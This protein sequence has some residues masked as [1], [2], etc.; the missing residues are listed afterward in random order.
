MRRHIAQLCSI[1]F[2]LLLPEVIY[3]AGGLSDQETGLISE[4]VEKIRSHSLVPPKSTR[5]MTEDILRSYSRTID[6]YGD[7]LSRE[8]FS[9]FMESTNSDYFGVQM[10]IRKKAGHIYLFPFK[11]GSAEKSGIQ[12]GDELVAINGAPVYGKSVFLIGSTIRGVEGK[13][14]QLTIRSGKG[15]PRVLSLRRQETSYASVRSATYDDGHYI[16]LTRFTKNTDTR[17][18]EILA[19]IDGDDR[20]VVVDLRGNQG[21]S[22]RVARRCADFFLKKDT[23]L[24]KLRYRDVTMDIVAEE[25]ALNSSSMVIIQDN[26]TASAAEAFIAALTGNGRAVALGSTTYG[27]GLA[28][29][30]LPLSDGSALLL[31]YAEILSPDNF[32][33]NDVGFKPDIVL[34]KDLVDKDYSTDSSFTSLL[35]FIEMNQK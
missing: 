27:K 23:V 22:L 19:M 5:G 31:T 13:T 20:V 12:A 9:A 4:A 17:L 24:F 14:V 8:E 25:D 1:L 15:I 11:G 32:A 18:Q 35:K 28:Q 26:N 29:R 3:G 33:H 10:D 34:P 16:Q 7:Y 6:E 21:G 2:L 30:F